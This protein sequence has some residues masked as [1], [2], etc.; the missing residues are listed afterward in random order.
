MWQDVNW[1]D[2][3]IILKLDPD[4]KIREDILKEILSYSGIDAVIVGGTQNITRDN[5]EVLLQ[6]I[7]DAD[8]EGPLIQEISELQA[9]SVNVDGY[10]LPVVLNAGHRDWFIGQHLTGIKALGHLIN[11]SQVLVEAY[12]ICNPDSAAARRTQ[13]IVPDREDLL[14]YQT[15]IEEVYAL[16]ILYVEYSGRYGNPDWLKALK[17]RRKKAHIFY[18]GGIESVPQA[19]EMGSLADTIIIGNLIYRQPQKLMEILDH[20]SKKSFLQEAY[21]D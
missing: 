7:H 10:L 12:V 21:H 1:R 17:E 15:L 19:E 8:Y 14:A 16:P 13:A 9:V 4:K 18:G 11:W 2:W 5:T 20:R 3:G 6:I